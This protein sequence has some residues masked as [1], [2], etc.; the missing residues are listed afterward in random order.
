MT[1][2][3]LI[4]ILIAISTANLICIFVLGA[5]IVKFRERLDGIFSDLLE[6]AETMWGAIPASQPV[7]ASKLKTWD[8]KYEEELEN[9]QRRLR[10]DSGLLDLPTPGGLSSGEI[11]KSKA[12]PSE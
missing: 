11:P 8:Q 10:G 4:F 7:V 6:M 12:N 9:I 1:L 2:Y 5:F 3:I